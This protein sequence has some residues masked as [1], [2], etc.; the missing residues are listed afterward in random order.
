MPSDV[1]KA[2][3]DSLEDEDTATAPV[4]NGSG[5][6]LDDGH[7]GRRQVL[8]SGFAPGLVDAELQLQ[9][10]QCYSSIED[11]RT[12]LHMRT[13]FY[14]YK[15]L[16]V[17][18]QGPNTKANEALSSIGR[19]IQCTADKYRAARNALR[20]LIGSRADWIAEYHSQIPV[21]KDTDIRALGA[22]DLE[23]VCRKRKMKK[24]KKIAEGSVK[25][26]WI[27]RGADGDGD[28]G[29]SASMCDI[30]ASIPTANWTCFRGACRV[31]ESSRTCSSMERRASSPSRGD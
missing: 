6:V 19:R 15:K 18:H 31:D 27:W 2:E 7:A 24:G 28:D 20:S 10:A 17:R 12:K 8:V 16:N 11:L 21:L 4:P 26:S 1:L 3:R 22:D 29:L 9:R 13:R 14:S 5:A 23:T 25:V 30:H